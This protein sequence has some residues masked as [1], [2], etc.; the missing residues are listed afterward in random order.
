MNAQRIFIYGLFCLGVFLLSNQNLTAKSVLDALQYQISAGP[1][2]T[3]KHSTKMDFPFSDYSYSASLNI[4]YQTD[5]SK[6][7]HQKSYFPKFGFNVHFIDYRNPLLGQ[8][9]GLSPT[10]VLPVFKTNSWSS[11]LYL[12][13]GFGWMTKP[14]DRN[15]PRNL[16]IGSHLNNFSDIQFDINYA[17]DDDA[18]HRLGAKFKFLHVSNAAFTVPNLGLNDVSLHLAYTYQ[19]SGEVERPEKVIPDWSWSQWWKKGQI[20]AKYVHAWTQKY[21]SFGPTY[22]IR[23]AQIMWSQPYRAFKNVQLGYHYEYN[24]GVYSFLK[25][26][27]EYAG[28]ERKHSTQHS[29]YIGHEFRWGA[30]G[31]ITQLG[32][33][34]Q[35]NYLNS[36]VIYQR[37]GGHIYL[38]ENEKYWLKGMYVSAILKTHLSVAEYAEFGI[39]IYF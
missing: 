11:E 9:I 12:G 34:L 28:Q 3:L 18:Q 14:H 25:S 21:P 37:L 39:G 32:G 8:G 20:H 6:E 29:I 15:N 38:F 22:N 33:Y 1:G 26:I 4:A 17:L 31:L 36:N 10:I 30:F 19:P 16:A 7:W 13:M 35:K 24:E 2:K 5:G 27:Y 23:G